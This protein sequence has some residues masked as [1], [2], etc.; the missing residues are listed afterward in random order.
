ML[1]QD[2]IRDMVNE[3]NPLEQIY[4]DRSSDMDRDDDNESM[5][6]CLDCSKTKS[7]LNIEGC[8]QQ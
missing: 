6:Y 4:T 7:K 1:Q 5:E 2:G 8:S 3:V